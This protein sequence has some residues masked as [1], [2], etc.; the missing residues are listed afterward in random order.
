[1]ENQTYQLFLS[2]LTSNQAL[3]FPL[4]L[5]FLLIYLLTLTGNSLI[6]LLISTDSHLQTPMYFF[7]GT[8]ACLDM[9]CSSVITPRL[10]F[11]S[12]TSKRAISLH[13]CMA[14]IF[15]LLFFIT[16]EVFLLSAMSY[17]RYIAICH[18]LHYRQIMHQRACTQMI[19]GVLIVS[20]AY[21]LLH[22]ICANRLR[23]C[24]LTTLQ[25]FFCDLPQ[26]LQFS[27]TD[28]FINL[29]LVLFF[30]SVIGLSNLAITL[31]PYIRIIS[32]ILKIKSKNMRHKAFSTC[33]S[34]LT[35]VIM[36]YGTCS[37]NYFL[38]NTSN[39][40]KESIVS[41]F[42]TILTPLLNPLIYSLRNKELKTA[43][44]RTL[45]NICVYK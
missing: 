6:L 30:G 45:H 44:R 19:S 23:F 7:L 29:L 2:G 33:S 40:S 4:F 31:Y 25:S 38:T 15:F 37:F 26:L 12:Y 43:F 10:L 3:Q 21:S 11:D 41:I 13:D 5:L 22:T 42:Y 9:S 36:F 28:T 18:P 1:M 27:C 39:I 24:H 17:D 8:L 35:V 34:H 32:T 20:I 14:Q 16:S